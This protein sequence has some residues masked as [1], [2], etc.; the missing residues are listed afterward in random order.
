MLSTFHTLT[1]QDKKL[2]TAK[3]LHEINYSQESFNLITRLIGY[4]DKHPIKEANYFNNQNTKQLNYD[5]RIN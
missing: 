2:L 3:I 1:D 4:W 5:N